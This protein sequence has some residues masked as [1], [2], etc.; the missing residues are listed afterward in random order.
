MS[1]SQMKSMQE[2]KL[3]TA[4]KEIDGAERRPRFQPQKCH[5]KVHVVD[6]E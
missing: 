4:S 2:R 5:S 1:Q 6:A 3:F